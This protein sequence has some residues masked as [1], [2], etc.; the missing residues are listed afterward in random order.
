MTATIHPLHGEIQ[1]PSEQP[2]QWDY[3]HKV[4]VTLARRQYQRV[5]ALKF[6]RDVMDY[7]AQQGDAYLAM[8]AA[9]FLE[10]LEKAE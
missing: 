3:M 2:S 7:A 4:A 9:N 6:A 1:S 8:S 5:W 10:Q